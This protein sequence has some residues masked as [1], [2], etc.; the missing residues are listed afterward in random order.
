MKYDQKEIQ[1][2]VL[3]RLQDIK[4]DLPEALPL[5]D[6]LKKDWGLDSL[7]LVELVARIEYQYQIMIEDEAL[8]QFYNIENIVDFLMRQEAVN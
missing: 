1:D 8:Q 4:P 2:F 5:K 6:H 3:G 7:D